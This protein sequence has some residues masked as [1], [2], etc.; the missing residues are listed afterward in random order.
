MRER[1][2]VVNEKDCNL[3]ERR[4]MHKIKKKYGERESE[5]ER[6][7]KRIRKIR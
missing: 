5:K 3:K 1:K 4:Y 2:R 6:E 7:I